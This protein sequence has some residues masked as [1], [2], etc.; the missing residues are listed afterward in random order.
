MID[1]Y[2]L[3]NFQLIWVNEQLVLSKNF[4][5]LL[6]SCIQNQFRFII[7]PIGI[8]LNIGNHSNYIIYDSKIKEVERFEPYGSDNPFQFNY[9]S[10]KLDLEISNIFR[11][12]DI[13]IKY[14]KP[15]DYMPKVGLQF[16]ESIEQTR[17]IGDP[18]GFC[19]LWTTWYADMRLT[20]IDIDRSKLINK[21]INQLKK[22]DKGTKNLI[23]N[24]SFEVTSL[25]D[26]ALT[27]AGITINDWINDQYQEKN[28]VLLSN[29]IN[30]LIQK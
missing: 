22:L 27:Y 4:K 9:D 26:S 21:I 24:Y 18:S 10:K 6:D 19:S 23:R 17:Y 30:L 7:I 5:I 20:Y 12:I 29:K 2:I 28:T 14:I 13:Q 8:Q 15:S 25:R 16:I 11:E 1:P 3:S